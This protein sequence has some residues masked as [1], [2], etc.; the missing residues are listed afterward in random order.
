[1]SNENRKKEEANLCAVIR[2]PVVQI[3]ILKAING[4][5]SLLG[6]G[7]LL[8]ILLLGMGFVSV[9][10]SWIT[11]TVTIVFA[12][13]FIILSERASRRSARCLNDIEEFLEKYEEKREKYEDK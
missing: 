4:V 3:G 1:M 7:F 12:I 5:M 6:I 2:K 13:M 10:F 8:L 9:H 11:V